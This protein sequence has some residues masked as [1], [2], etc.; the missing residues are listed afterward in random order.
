MTDTPVAKQPFLTFLDEFGYYS[1]SFNDSLREDLR[2]VDGIPNARYLVENGR[3]FVFEKLVS[4]ITEKRR[5]TGEVLLAQ[6]TTADMARELLPQAYLSAEEAVRDWNIVP[7]PYETKPLTTGGYTIH[8]R[9][10]NARLAATFET[11]EDVQAALVHL[12]LGGIHDGAGD[13]VYRGQPLVL[14]QSFDPHILPFSPEIS[15]GLAPA[16]SFYSSLR[17]TTYIP[18]FDPVSMERFATIAVLEDAWKNS[19]ARACA[20]AS[21]HVADLWARVETLRLD[22]LNDVTDKVSEYGLE[23]FAELKPLYPELSMLCDGSLYNWFDSYQMDCCY[24]SG[25]TA[26]RDNDFL[27]YLLG[28]VAGRDFDAEEAVEVGRWAAYALL[29][30]DGLDAALQFARSA[31]VYDRAISR[32]ANRVDNAMRFLKDDQRTDQAARKGSPVTTML[33]MF[34]M[35]RK[36]C[37]PPMTATQE[38]ADF[39]A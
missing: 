36:F 28:K 24:I 38:L 3:V 21:S 20:Q 11:K 7:E 19:S 37:L 16:R 32:L 26:N 10:F 5:G 39:A 13:F 12:L 14:C 2:A 30:G 27:F 35:G 4:L 17:G 31:T 8:H 9:A 6:A 18:G 34:R 33:D 29:R 22:T 25:W 23:D 1:A 15:G